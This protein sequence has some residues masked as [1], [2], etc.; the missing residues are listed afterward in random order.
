MIEEIV[1]LR[2][3]DSIFIEETD[4]NFFT[5]KE[6]QV[7]RSSLIFGRNGS[8]KSTITRAINKV[9]TGEGSAEIS[10]L[11]GLDSSNEGL[12]SESIF[13]FNEE[14]IDKNIKLS[15]D[16]LDTIVIFGEENK[17][18]EIL[19][20]TEKLK[21]EGLVKLENYEKLKNDYTKSP[22]HIL[23]N[24][25][26]KLKGK[27]SWASRDSQIKEMKI[28]SQVKK[29]E[30]YKKFINLEPNSSRDDLILSF[31]R[32]KKNYFDI[33]EDFQ[34][35]DQ[36][37]NPIKINLDNLKLM[38]LLCEQ[39][40]EPKISKREIFLLK[41]LE[42]ANR[43]EDHLRDIENYFS[44]DKK[45]VICLYCTQS[46]DSE[47][48]KDL[49]ES[50]KNILSELVDRHKDELEKQ[51]IGEVKIDFDEYDKLDTRL[52]EESK[53]NMCALNEQLEKINNLIKKKIKHPYTPVLEDV[54]DYLGKLN[55]L[56]ES[57]NS[58]EKER[59][60]YNQSRTQI[61]KYKE[62]LFEINNKIAHY[63]IIE[64]Y[65]KYEEQLY[66]KEEN[67]KNYFR[68]YR[69]I[70]RVGK[71]KQKLNLLKANTTIAM[72]QINRGLKY[73][74]FSENRLLVEHINGKYYLISRGN[75][76]SPDKV[77]IG[78]RN[79]IAIC[80]YFAEI[81]RNKEQKNGYKDEYF[82]VLDDPISSLDVGN[83]IGIQS[84]LR[85]MLKRFIM[86]NKNT[87]ALILTHDR[88]VYFDLTKVLDEIMKTCS[89]D[90][91]KSKLN[92]FELIDNKLKLGALKDG[93]TDLLEEVYDFAAVKKE[94]SG[95]LTEEEKEELT[96]EEEIKSQGIG[97][98]MRKLLEAFGTFTYKEG[99]T[100][101]TENQEILS[102]IDTNL[103]DYFEN[104]VYR[105]VLNGD[106]HSQD[107]IKS[108]NYN[109]FQYITVDEKRKTSK[110]ILVILYLLNDLHVLSH[111]KSKKDVKKNILVWKKEIEERNLKYTIQ[112]LN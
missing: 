48:K 5:K 1:G 93:Y 27:G 69:L 59:I 38:N 19:R 80:Y 60:Q 112:K 62:E 76:V 94:K 108:N 22:D 100:G 89:K 103:Q 36:V 26:Q 102:K 111:L 45:E 23:D 56:N 85:Y 54:P 78:E 2:I 29:L 51:I 17:I 40:E 88:Q 43:G 46:V 92:K 32:K 31:D 52:L 95:K 98:T 42:N 33:K 81:L 11:I 35:I 83:R 104:L 37:V 99:I 16:G 110:D 82:L 73:I 47:L 10:K 14:F 105:L 28:D 55:K 25:Q 68:L 53:A 67:E 44:S 65:K 86:G 20:E 79:A 77:S 15:N 58:L 96:K 24:I 107:N 7:V 18:D 8:G 66:L 90:G 74:F 12:I 64:L 72:E 61:D 71:Q 97:N 50:V 34:K 84:Y 101:L 9:K 109:L 39:L 41:L 106:S 57:L 30:T 70:L 3:K 91:E 6:Q 49:V 21:K 75:R 63:D 4:L 13:V 87:R